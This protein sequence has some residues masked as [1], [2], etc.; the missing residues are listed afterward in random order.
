M[1]IFFILNI[2]SFSLNKNKIKLATTLL[3]QT[4]ICIS[5]LSREI[6]LEQEFMHSRDHMRNPQGGINWK[7]Y[8]A[9]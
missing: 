4:Q 1:T 3:T 5:I 8:F 7:A 6:H 9:I 2:T